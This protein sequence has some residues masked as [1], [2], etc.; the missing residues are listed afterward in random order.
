MRKE[1]YPFQTSYFTVKFSGFAAGM[2][3]KGLKTAQKTAV[4]EK[5]LLS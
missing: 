3:V 4:Q 1:S 2:K 5:Q